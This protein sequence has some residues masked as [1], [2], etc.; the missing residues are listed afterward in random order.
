MI[1][2]RCKG[3]HRGWERCKPAV[4]ANTDNDVV[5]DQVNVVHANKSCGAR[6]DRHKDTPERREY[7]AQWMREYRKRKSAQ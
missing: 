6:K 1:C 3:N 2:K 4:V 7:R 5:H